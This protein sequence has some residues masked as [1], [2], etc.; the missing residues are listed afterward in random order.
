MICAVTSR[1]ASLK[2]YKKLDHDSYQYRRKDP[3]LRLYMKL[4]LKVIK[5]IYYSL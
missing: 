2:Y 4:I 1:Q 5:I 3:S